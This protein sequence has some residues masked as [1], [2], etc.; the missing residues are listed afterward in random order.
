MGQVVTMQ[1]ET[2]TFTLTVNDSGANEDNISKRTLKSHSAYENKFYVT[3]TSFAVDRGGSGAIGVS[4]VELGNPI[5]KSQEIVFSTLDPLNV[6][7]TQTYSPVTPLPGEYYYLKARMAGGAGY[8]VN[9][10]GRYTP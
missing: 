8:M 10:K 2:T 5:N 1:A 9:M 7:K 6:T 4:S 3:P